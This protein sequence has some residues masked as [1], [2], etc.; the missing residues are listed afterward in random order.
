MRGEKRGR[1]GKCQGDEE[2]TSEKWGRRKRRDREGGKR[3]E[4]KREGSERD[5]SA[6]I[7]R[8]G[9]ERGKW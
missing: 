8:G 9:K 3:E 5:S 4:G 6:D 2:R 7:Q 1:K